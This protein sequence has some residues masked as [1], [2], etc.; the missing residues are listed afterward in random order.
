MALAHAYARPTGPSSAG[1]SASPSTTTASTTWCRSSTSLCSP[2]T[3]GGAGSGLSPLRGQN[4]VQGGGDMGA[5]PNR[6]PGFQ[7]ILDDEARATFD[8]PGERRSHRATANT[9]PPCSRP[10]STASCGPS[11]ASARTRPSRRPTSARPAP[12]RRPRPPRRAGHLPHPH[13]G[14]GRRRPAA[15]AGWCESEGTV[16]NSE[17]RVQRVRKALQ[18]P[19]APATTSTSCSPSLS[20]SATSGPTGR[21]GRRWPSGSRPCGTSCARCRPCTTA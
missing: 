8:R 18:P 13:R 12:P 9:S 20:G 14:D 11:S 19:R 7:D 15:T 5:I 16:T 6:L 1:R 21:P 4:N 3:S 2:V 10:W 17:R